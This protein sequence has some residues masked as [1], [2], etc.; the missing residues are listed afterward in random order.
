MMVDAAQLKYPTENNIQYKYCKK[1]CKCYNKYSPVNPCTRK[2]N[3]NY[4][5]SCKH[6]W[7]LIE[8]IG[9]KTIM[10]K[11]LKAL[12]HENI[13]V[14]YANYPVAVYYGNHITGL[15][16]KNT[17]LTDNFER[18]IAEFDDVYLNGSSPFY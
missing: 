2:C 17:E 14:E 11:L 18:I 1:T 7:T 13:P 5:K 10:L 3:E 8:I 6:A 15:K 9:E 16:I 4:K 12:T